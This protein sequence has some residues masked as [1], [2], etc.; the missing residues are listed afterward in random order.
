MKHGLSIIIFFASLL[1]G[2]DAQ[3]ASPSFHWGN[4]F[5]YNLDKGESVTFRG[6]EV[7]LLQLQNHYNQLKIGSDTVWLRVSRR[8]LPELVNG[9][10][11]FVAD[12]KF[13]KELAVNKKIHGLLKK[14]ALICLSDF[15]GPLLDINRYVFP[16]SFSGGFVWST[17]E[18]SYLFSYQGGGPAAETSDPG[19]HPG[20]DFDLHDARGKEKHWLVAPEKS[21]VAWIESR[22]EGMTENE[23]A[24]LLESES[25][26]GIFYLYE[27]LYR[28]NLAVRE[29][30]TLLPGEI[31]GTIW[32]DEV[33]GNLHFAVLKSDSVPPWSGRY[34]NLVNGF[35]QL[36]ELYFRQTTGY[37]KT[38]SKGRIYFGRRRDLNRNQKNVMAFEPYSGKG[39]ELGRWNPAEKVEWAM[40]NGD[41]N[42]RLRKVLFEGSAAACKNPENFFDFEI[43]V[44]N[45][46]YRIRAE[47]GDLY[48]PSWQK[49]TFEGVDA[50]RFSLNPGQAEWTT[51]RIVKVTDGKLTVRIYID[52]E[53]QRVAG[54]REIVFQ[55]IN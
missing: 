3:N 10:R 30:Q 43:N 21:R 20:I 34:N 47:V 31:L 4:G 12:N 44:Q 1:T 40:K 55:H 48:L 27:H 7:R 16:V 54:L 37:S 23:A 17:E 53:N 32:G 26:P 6:Q 19:T 49:I 45:G 25:T 24:V 41:G 52:P 38:F 29:G 11:V 8:A 22:R 28:K 33:W 9:M 51:E 5:Y 39:W 46:T 14:D 2:A 13:V 36:Y 42:A 18:S 50:G 15:Q 35:P